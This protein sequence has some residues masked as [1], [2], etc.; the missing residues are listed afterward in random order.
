MTASPALSERHHG[1]WYELCAR[2]C[3]EQLVRMLKVVGYDVGFSPGE[4]AYLYDRDGT[5]CLDLLN[6]FGVF[7]IGRNHST[8]R[9]ALRNVL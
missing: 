3:N 5:R 9:A 8:V 2:Y 1:D 4:G 7:A 6:G